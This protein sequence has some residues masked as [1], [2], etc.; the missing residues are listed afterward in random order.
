[1]F[2]KKLQI[3]LLVMEKQTFWSDYQL[4][5]DLI[6]GNT[7]ITISKIPITARIPP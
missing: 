2:Q 5:G 1:M 3:F 7:E 4:E 6:R